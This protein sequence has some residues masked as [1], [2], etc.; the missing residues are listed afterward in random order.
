[1]LGRSAS[2][3]SPDGDQLPLALGLLQGTTNRCKP[4][5]YSW[6]GVTSQES[7]LVN[8]NACGHSLS[9]KRLSP[10]GDLQVSLNHP[11]TLLINELKS[12]L[13]G[14]DRDDSSSFFLLV[15]PTHHG[16]ELVSGRRGG[17]LD[18]DSGCHCLRNAFPHVT[19][20]VSAS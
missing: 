7:E 19:Q 10:G 14:L 6:L 1:M 12:A 20:I 2:L 8:R 5:R 18:T 17:L 16:L 9:N 11:A 4:L 13:S 3:A 15:Q